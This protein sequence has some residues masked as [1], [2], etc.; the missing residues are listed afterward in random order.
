MTRGPSV[1]IERPVDWIDTDAAG[2][3]HH[4]SV[5][6]WVEAAEAE[7]LDRLGVPGLVP[8]VP[9]VRY[10]VDYLD[11]LYFRDRVA[12]DLWVDRVGGSSLRYGFEVTREGLGPA[13]RGAMTCVNVEPSTGSATPWPEDLARAFRDAAPP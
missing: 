7:L 11:R 4:S 6:R 1:R 12:V 2:H 5:I 9:R 10:E 13:A 3:Y 8:T